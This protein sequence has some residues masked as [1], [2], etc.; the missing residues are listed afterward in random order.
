MSFL[1]QPHPFLAWVSFPTPSCHPY[2]T[3]ASLLDTSLI[4]SVSVSYIFSVPAAST[5]FTSSIPNFL[6]LH[7]LDIL[8]PFHPLPPYPLGPYSLH[9]FICLFQTFLSLQSA[10]RLS[11][12]DW[13]L[14]IG[15]ATVGQLKT[16]GKGRNK[17][18]WWKIFGVSFVEQILELSGWKFFF[19]ARLFKT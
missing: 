7:I 15:V 6:C 11:S 12:A 1:P 2:S 4:F 17:D 13:L 5:S 3:L 14:S 8:R 9:S 19:D 16:T 10:F 18:T